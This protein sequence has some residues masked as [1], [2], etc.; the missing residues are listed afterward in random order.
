MFWFNLDPAQGNLIVDFRFDTMI[1][2]NQHRLIQL[3]IENGAN[4]DVE[5]NSGMTPLLKASKMGNYTVCKILLDSGA[6]KHL[7]ES[8]SIALQKKYIRISKLLDIY[9]I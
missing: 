2:T 3:L 7:V 9:S 4:V 6:K 8:K 5:S 1:V